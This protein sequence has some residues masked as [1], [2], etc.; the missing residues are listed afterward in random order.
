[1]NNDLDFLKRLNFELRTLNDE[2]FN[3]L[4]FEEHYP[5]IFLLGLPRSGTT[6]LSQL[7]FNNLKIGC[8]NNLMAR[9]W[10]T[11]FCGMKLSSII[12]GNNKSTSYD[13]YYGKTLE[14]TQPHE[15]SWFWHN[16]LNITDIEKYN[17]QEARKMI[18]WV[19]VKNKII[20]FNK[21]INQP[22]VHKPLEL[23]IYHASKFGFLFQKSIFIFLSRD[24]LSVA[25]SLVNARLTYYNNINKWWGSYPLNYQEISNI[26]GYKQIALQVKNLAEM[27]E[28]QLEHLPQN[29]L[30]NVTYNELCHAPQSLLEKV[31]T[32]SRQECNFE[33]EQINHPKPFKV[34]FPKS[35]EKTTLIMEKELSKILTI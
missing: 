18:N 16:L 5:N 12:L 13:S 8:T 20:A 28:I 35:Y 4:D 17:I 22:L 7:L 34:S 9:F 27:Y 33:L 29:R 3:S 15:F 26:K 10:E 21:I 31:K 11:P 1:M 19:Q 32:I 25:C 2:I 24:L 14:V 23:M 30:I 6:L